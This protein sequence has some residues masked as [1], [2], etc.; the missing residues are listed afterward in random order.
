MIVV[1]FGNATEKNAAIRYR[2]I[3]FAQMFEKEGHT[4]N[5]C[6][7]SSASLWEQLW[8]NG[9][10]ASKSLYSVY[11][12]VRRILQLR[13]VFGA[14]VVFFRGPVFDYGPPLFERVIHLFNSHM[15]YDIDDAVWERPAYVSSPF[16]ALVDFDWTWKMCQ[17]CAHGIVGNKYLKECVE[18]H[19]P[20]V[21]IIPTCVDMDR[22]PAKRYP[23]PD[24]QRPVVLGWTGQHNNLGYFEIIEDVL[25]DLAK[26]YRIVL[27]VATSMD[28]HLDG[29]EVINHR[30]EITH[31]LDYLQEADIGL[32]P[33]T[34][35]KRALGKCAF[36]ALEY[37]GVG[38]PC[39]IS[40][41]GMNAEIIEDGVTGFLA[42][43]PEEWYQ[44][45]E[46]LIAD[47]D[48]RERIGRAA[49]QVVIER[50]S[51]DVHYPTFRSVMECVART[52]SS[53]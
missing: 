43:T 17:M 49:R 42:E 52:K 41:V 4:C 48:L 45:L 8:E 46:A 28:Y 6:L 16:L 26:K 30:W 10:R 29:I 22:H 25:R 44:K 23:L 53:K 31:E 38:T 5:V 21:T 34:R 19:N 14:D 50:Y 13:H 15:V 33:L 47:H 3:R 11:V 36:K 39:V 7:P 27:S 40:P 2:V 32:M 24:S 35:S 20:N 37:M 12:F 9:N 51:H 1:L 18:P